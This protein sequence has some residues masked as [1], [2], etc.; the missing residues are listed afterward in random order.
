MSSLPDAVFVAADK[1]GVVVFQA[2]SPQVQGWNEGRG[3]RSLRKFCGHY[4]YLKGRSGRPETPDHGP[5][6]SASAAYADAI[7]RLEVMARDDV[8][9]ARV[10][11]ANALI[12]GGAYA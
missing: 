12:V 9:V 10:L 8:R 6:S 11:R 5:F 4:W 2:R 1:L 7:T 3:A